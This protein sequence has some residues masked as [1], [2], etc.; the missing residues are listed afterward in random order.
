MMRIV[1]LTLALAWAPLA[2][3][4][5]LPVDTTVATGTETAAGQQPF[6][7]RTLTINPPSTSLADFRGLL[8]NLNVETD[9][10]VK[11]LS[12]ASSYAYHMGDG[13]ITEAIYGFTGQ[14]LNYGDGNEAFSNGVFGSVRQY[15][16][17]HVVDGR[18]TAGLL[19][20]Y[21]PSG[22][23]GIWG[24]AGIYGETGNRSGGRMSDPSAGHFVISNNGL[25][26]SGVITRVTMNNSGTIPYAYGVRI[27]WVN[28]GTIGEGYLIYIN[29]PSG[30]APTTGWTIYSR[31]PWPI[32]FASDIRIGS[33]NAQGLQA[34]I[35]ALEA[36]IAALE[37]AQ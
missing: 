12:A 21:R 3:A 37:A 31:S 16:G 33:P 19:L 10:D 6:D 23:V 17:G 5:T 27:N 26:D 8:L 35:A 1:L 4:Q 24:G 36:R 30:T 11:K 32:Y 2:S 13:D 7:L 22:G 18:G 9:A 28:A 14:T 20:N 34:Q 15:G 29:Q 25:I